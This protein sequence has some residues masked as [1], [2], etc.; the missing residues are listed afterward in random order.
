MVSGFLTPS[1]ILRVPD[2][3][4]DEELD[5]GGQWPKDENMASKFERLSNILNMVKTTIGL[6]IKWLIK[7]LRLP[8]L[9]FNMYFPGSKQFLPSTMLQITV[10][11]HWMPY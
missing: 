1:G 3:I 10:P 7:L 8:Y 4:S 2:E 9:S 11:L 6:G 5:R